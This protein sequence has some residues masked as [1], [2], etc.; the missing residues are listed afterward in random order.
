MHCM[1]PA[2]CQEEGGSPG[3]CHTWI[4]RT[5]AAEAATTGRYK[6][7][8]HC[9]ATYLISRHCFTAV[10]QD[11]HAAERQTVGSYTRQ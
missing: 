10:L 7:T 8:P 1:M 3:S 5:A 9:S 11:V 2:A 4:C 6:A